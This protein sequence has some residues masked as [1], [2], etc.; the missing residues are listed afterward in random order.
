[1]KIVDNTLVNSVIYHYL[2]RFLWLSTHNRI[3]FEAGT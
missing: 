3:L 2:L 1:M